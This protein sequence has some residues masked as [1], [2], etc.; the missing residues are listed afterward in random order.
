[1]AELI[2]V[3]DEKGEKTGRTA[4]RDEVHCDGLWHRVIAVAVLD[5]NNQILLQQRSDNKL[6]NPGKWDITTAGHV[7]AGEESLESAKRELAEEVGINADKL[8]YLFSYSKQ[9]RPMTRE[10]LYKDNQIAD[11]FLVRVPKINLNEL[12]L[13]E[14]EVQAMKLCS[15][16]EFKEMVKS[17]KMVNRAP[18][19][20]KL[21]DIMQEE[22]K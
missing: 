22:E 13:Q 3:L 6:T 1:M 10:G 11:C 7:D 17:G 12:K 2:D 4:T 9:S 18:F 21:I 19:Y 20:E 8:E 14:E 5:E 15:L 16:M